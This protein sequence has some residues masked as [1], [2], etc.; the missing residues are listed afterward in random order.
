MKIQNKQTIQCTIF[1][2]HMKVAINGIQSNSLTKLCLQKRAFV[3]THVIKC[4]CNYMETRLVN[5]NMTIGSPRSPIPFK[6]AVT[7]LRSCKSPLCIAHKH[8]N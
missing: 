1:D 3:L 5:E 4:H 6:T 8:D 2:D 7:Q